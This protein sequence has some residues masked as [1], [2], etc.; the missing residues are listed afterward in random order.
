VRALI[1][2]AA[3]ET[4]YI[5][6]VPVLDDEGNP[7]GKLEDKVIE[8]GE[9]GYL[10]ETGELG[11]LKWLARNHPQ[12]FAPL[13]GRIIPLEMNVKDT[14]KPPR[15]PYRSV[16]EIKAALRAKGIDPDVIQRAMMVQ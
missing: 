1:R 3:E 5:A 8:T 7:T 4:G 12:Q 11:Y 6:S 14:T 2:Q 10:I 16:E 9:L 15:I 13:Y